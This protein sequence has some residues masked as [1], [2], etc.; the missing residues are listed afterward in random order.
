LRPY[1]SICRVMG[2]ILDYTDSDSFNVQHT[3]I[4]Y[5]SIVAP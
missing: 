3:K 2:Q 4:P 1:I 5:R